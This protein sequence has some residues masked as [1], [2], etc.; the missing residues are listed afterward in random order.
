MNNGQIFA[1]CYIGLGL[2]LLIGCMI[3]AVY[4]WFRAVPLLNKLKNRL[5]GLNPALDLRL[6]DFFQF[7]GIGLSSKAQNKLNE[8]VFGN[9]FS[10]FDDVNNLRKQ[11]RKYFLGFFRAI[12]AGFIVFGVFFLWIILLSN[13]HH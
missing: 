6:S 10:E 13:H 8:T 3:R 11:V 2:T 9:N 1:T 12:A 7:S 5:D 4:C